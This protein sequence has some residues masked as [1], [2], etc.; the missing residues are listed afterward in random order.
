M[1]EYFQIPPSVRHCAT[2]TFRNERNG[3]STIK[4]LLLAV[5]L[6]AA[7]LVSVGDAEDQ[8]APGSNPIVRDVFAADPSPLVVGDTVYLYVG[9]DNA[10]GR[11]MFTM[12]EWLCY[13]SKD[14]KSWTSHGTVLRPTDFTWGEANSAWAA[15]VVPK[16]GKFCYYVTVKGNR[17]APG[18]NV[19]VAVADSP[20][21]PFQDAIGKPLIRDD[22]TPDARRPWEDIDPTVWIDDDG[23]PWMSWGNGDCYLVKLKP[24]MIELDGTIEKIDLPHYVEGPWLFKRDKLYYLV[25]AAIRR[26]VGSEQIAYATAE[27]ITGPWTFRE[28]ITGPAKNSFTIHPGVIAF[29]GQWYFFYHFAGLTI[30]GQRGALGRRAVCLEYL[31]FN[32]DGT[33]KP[34]TQTEAGVSVLPNE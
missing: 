30:N 25:Y 6:I 10:K 4:P 22:M 27:I 26:P 34:I 24:N 16:D 13:S 31:D 23:T 3:C 21:G 14:M 8:P 15:Q 18:N 1:S 33:I 29:K 11:E 19:G 32:P 17:T 12:P 2:I 9:H 20:T 28:F 7:I 5:L